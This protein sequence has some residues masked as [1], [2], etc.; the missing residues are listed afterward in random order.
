MRIA[1]KILCSTSQTFIQ[2]K[3]L[4]VQTVQVRFLDHVITEVGRDALTFKDKFN[5]HEPPLTPARRV[6]SMSDL[7][8]ESMHS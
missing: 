1:K 6:H 5:T 4:G 7:V 8:G 3:V 2:S